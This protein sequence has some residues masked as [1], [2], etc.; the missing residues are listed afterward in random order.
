M[1][2]VCIDTHVLVWY[3][4]KPSRLARGA[5]RLLRRVDAGSAEI[6]IPAITVIELG[7]LQEAGRR[8]PGAAQVEALCAAQPA[9]RIAALDLSVATEFVLLSAL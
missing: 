8:V 5:R 6:F 4:S 1:T 9:F 3:L 2:R 7:L